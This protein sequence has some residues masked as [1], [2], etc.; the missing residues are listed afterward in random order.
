MREWSFEPMRD[1]L[2]KDRII[3]EQALLI[4]NLLTPINKRAAGGFY[5]KLQ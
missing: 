5:P 3:F 1:Q 2:Y 4:A